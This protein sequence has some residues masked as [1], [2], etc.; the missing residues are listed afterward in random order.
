[1][2]KRKHPLNMKESHYIAIA[3]FKQGKI[4]FQQIEQTSRILR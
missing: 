2:E 3:K 1:M 4:L